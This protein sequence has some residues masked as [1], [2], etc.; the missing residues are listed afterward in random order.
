MT[1]DDAAPPADNDHPLYNGPHRIGPPIRHTF[2]Q[3]IANRLRTTAAA[4]AAAAA[5]R[6]NNLSKPRAARGLQSPQA[7]SA[8]AMHI[9]CA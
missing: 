1:P 5:A 3:Y 2:A 6:F 9:A 4:G 8:A 7:H